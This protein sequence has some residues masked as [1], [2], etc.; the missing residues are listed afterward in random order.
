MGG[1]ATSN[2]EDW[3]WGSFRDRTDYC[4]VEFSFSNFFIETS[5]FIFYFFKY[6]KESKTFFKKGNFCMVVSAK[7]E[8]QFF[9]SRVTLV[10]P[11]SISQFNFLDC[12]AHC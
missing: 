10:Q 1:G 4:V 9:T 3:G 6:L 8:S 7:W 2:R 12:I 11:V 5:L